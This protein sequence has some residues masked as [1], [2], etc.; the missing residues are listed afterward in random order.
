M[1]DFGTEGF[2]IP[3]WR[4]TGHSSFVRHPGVVSSQIRSR[5]S[6]MESLPKAEGKDPYI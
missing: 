1:V 4:K 2:G 3:E 5:K 6:F